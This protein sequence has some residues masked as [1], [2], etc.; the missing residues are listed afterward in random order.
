MVKLT[1]PAT[2]DVAAGVA[3]AMALCLDGRRSQA[4]A[5]GFIVGSAFPGFWRRGFR[6]R[7]RSVRQQPDR[8]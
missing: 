5:R 3:E 7:G 6:R 4:N 8:E 2:A 1:N